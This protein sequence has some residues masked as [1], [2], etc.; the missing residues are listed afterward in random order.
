[1]REISAAN[2]PLSFDAAHSD[3]RIDLAAVLRGLE[4]DDRLLL[5]LRYGST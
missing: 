5:G 1:V 2:P 3:N 4:P